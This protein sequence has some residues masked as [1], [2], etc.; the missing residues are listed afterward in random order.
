MRDFSHIQQRKDVREILQLKFQSWKLPEKNSHG[1]FIL[2]IRKLR[3]R[4]SVSC[5]LYKARTRTRFNTQVSQS[6]A[7]PTTQTSLSLH[8]NS[9]SPPFPPVPLAL[10][11]PSSLPPASLSS[12]LSLPLTLPSPPSTSVFLLFLYCFL[13][14]LPPSLPSCLSSIWLTVG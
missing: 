5:K 12:S 14:S 8:L 1:D 2:Q 3:P 11:L 13:L 7:F 10:S 9:F 6:G 4:D